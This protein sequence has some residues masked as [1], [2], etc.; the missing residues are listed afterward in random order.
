[1]SF[2]L[3]LDLVKI[4]PVDGPSYYHAVNNKHYDA[5]LAGNLDENKFGKWE[6]VGNVYIDEKILNELGYWY[7]KELGENN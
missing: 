1:M 4:I 5:M 7:T 2:L 3:E 6:P